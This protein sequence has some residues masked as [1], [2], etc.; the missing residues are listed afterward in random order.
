MQFVKESLIRATPERV[1]AFHEQ[2]DALALLLPPWES[3]RVVQ[4]AKISEVGS[5]AVV[6][7][8]VFGPLT[9][10]WIAE[11][12]LYDPPHVFE[13]I[14]IKGPFRS[15]RHRHIIEPH[16]DGAV[17][18]DQIDYELPLG[19]LGRAFAPL[20]VERRLQKLFDYRHEVTRKWCDGQ[21]G[22]RN[23]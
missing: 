12:T 17:L 4:P 18:R 2:P 3:A 21:E 14:Q 22:K 6:E 5:Q 23:E 16:A 11:H 15:W 7:T 8:S 20:L 10:R 19:F 13:D 1:F 9:M